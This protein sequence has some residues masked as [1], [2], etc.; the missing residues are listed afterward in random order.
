MASVRDD[1]ECEFF[2]ESVAK[3][4]GCQG[5]GHYQ[6]YA[7]ASHVDAAERRE[8]EREFDRL[9]QRMYAPGAIQVFD[10]LL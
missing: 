4:P 10:G 5:D 9:W 2:D 3:A 8:A 1:G 6:C 7:C